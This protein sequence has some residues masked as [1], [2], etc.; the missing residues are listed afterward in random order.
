MNT[1]PARVTCPHCG[2][3]MHLSIDFS[4]GD[5]DYFEECP[6]CANDV[7]LHMHID[8]VHKKLDV[9]ISADDEQLY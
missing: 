4:N 6:N 3:S 9:S 2:H 7:H 1:K 8:D 5:Q